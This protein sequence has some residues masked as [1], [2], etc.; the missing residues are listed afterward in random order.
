MAS[1]PAEATPPEPETMVRGGNNQQ[2]SREKDKRLKQ[3]IAAVDTPERFPHG[4]KIRRTPSWRRDIESALFDGEEDL[5]RAQRV[6]QQLR[7]L[8]A[9]VAEV[10][11]ELLRA[12]I[13]R[14]PS[15]RRHLCDSD[16]VVGGCG[17]EFAEEDGVL[18]DGCGLFLCH[19]CFGDTIVLN[20]TQVGGRYDLQIRV[21]P[22]SSS[23]VG[24]ISEP[25][26]LPCPL[27]P[28]KCLT[29][30]IQLHAIQVRA[31]SIC[32]RFRG[33]TSTQH[34]GKHPLAITPAL[35]R[36]KRHN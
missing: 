15:G 23:Q 24:A 14:G 3:I 35:M 19:P 29:G 21:P 1:P 7:L 17:V 10:K 6:R 18:C 9:D 27:F 32:T 8:D 12:E 31:R 5:A 2:R 33:P 34:L 13:L 20:E 11:A 28:Q 30:H 4:R 26:S 25:G 36:L 16:C 22:G